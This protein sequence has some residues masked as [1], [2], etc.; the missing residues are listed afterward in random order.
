MPICKTP[1]IKDIK[2]IVNCNYNTQYYVLYPLRTIH[3]QITLEP[4]IS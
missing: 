3:I 1:P 2:Y 4:G